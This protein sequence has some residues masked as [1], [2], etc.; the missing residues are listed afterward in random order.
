MAVQRVVRVFRRVEDPQE[1]RMVGN[2]AEVERPVELH[3][4]AARM[5]DRLVLREPVGVI[6][7]GAGAEDVG[8]ERIAGVDVQGA[9]VD[10]GHGKSGSC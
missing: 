7:A 2:G 9:E 8:V 1:E 5:P 6:G 3:L 4:E 10:F